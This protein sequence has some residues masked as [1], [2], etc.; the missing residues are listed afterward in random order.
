MFEKVLNT[1][2]NKQLKPLNLPN[3]SN[4]NFGIFRQ[5]CFKLLVVNT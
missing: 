5:T 1:P 2:L 4:N 3:F